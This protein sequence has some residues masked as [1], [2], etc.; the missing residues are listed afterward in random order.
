[1]EHMNGLNNRVNGQK[2]SISQQNKKMSSE[3]STEVPN[4]II[5]EQTKKIPNLV[6]LGLAFGS[7][8]GSAALQASNKKVLGNFVG[9]WVPTILAFG[10]YN[11]LVKIE[12]E[13]LKL[14]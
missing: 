11:K 3:F 8:L 5:E 12:D 13:I 6:F 4:E 1:M 7:I 14:H 2:G 10:I 9:L